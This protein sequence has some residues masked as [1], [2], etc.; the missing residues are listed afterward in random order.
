MSSH[1]RPLSARHQ[2]PR[3][4]I[5][6]QS[7]SDSDKKGA[8]EADGGD[9]EIE[10][11]PRQHAMQDSKEAEQAP[12]SPVNSIGAAS[13]SGHVRFDRDQSQ[14]R[15]HSNLGHSSQFHREA[16]RTGSVIFR[17]PR[18]I[19][20][21]H[22]AGS[23]AYSIGTGSR[24]L[25]DFG[26]LNTSNTLRQLQHLHSLRMA[27][28]MRQ[29]SSHHSLRMTDTEMSTNMSAN[30]STNTNN[31]HISDSHK[32]KSLN[33]SNNSNES[34]INNDTNENTLENEANEMQDSKNIGNENE[35]KMK[36]ETRDR[37]N[38]ESHGSK[39][40][41]ATG[42][43]T[44]ETTKNVSA[45][46]EDDQ[47]ERKQ[48]SS[49][50]NGAI[51]GDSVESNKNNNT[52]NDLISPVQT[53]PNQSQFRVKSDSPSNNTPVPNGTDIDANMT[54]MKD[55]N[56]ENDDKEAAAEAAINNIKQIKNTRNTAKKNKENI[57]TSLRSDASTVKSNRNSGGLLGNS[58]LHSRIS[59]FIKHVLP[60]IN[61]DYNNTGG[62]YA[63]ASGA[64]SGGIAPASGAASG[65]SVASLESQ[66]YRLMNSFSLRFKDARREHEFSNY[67]NE[68]YGTS[69]KIAMIAMILGYIFLTLTNEEFVKNSGKLVLTCLGLLVMLSA[70]SISTAKSHS[71][72]NTNNSTEVSKGN[73]EK[74][75]SKSNTNAN[76]GTH[77]RQKNTGMMNNM[78]AS[79]FSCI[80]GGCLLLLL[81]FQN[82][83]SV[84]MSDDTFLVY[85]I[86]C[87]AILTAYSDMKFLHFVGLTWFCWFLWNALAIMFSFDSVNNPRQ[88][89]SF[90]FSSV[91]VALIIAQIVFS[92]ELKQK[93]RHRR[94]QFLRRQDNINRMKLEQEIR[95]QTTTQQLHLPHAYTMSRSNALY[96]KSYALPNEGGLHGLHGYSMSYHGAYLTDT[97][98][99]YMQ[100]N[101]IHEFVPTPVNLNANINSNTPNIGLMP[102]S[103]AL[104]PEK[105]SNN[106][107]NSNAA[108]VNT[109]G[110]DDEARRELIQITRSSRAFTLRD[111]LIAALAMGNS[112]LLSD[113]NLNISINDEKVRAM[114]MRNDDNIN[115]NISGNNS[116]RGE[117][118]LSGGAIAA[119]TTMGNK[120]VSNESNQTA[121]LEGNYSSQQLISKSQ[122]NV[123]RRSNRLHPKSKA[124]SKS[125]QPNRD[126]RRFLQQQRNH[127]RNLLFAEINR[128]FTERSGSGF[129]LSAS[130][131]SGNTSSGEGGNINIIKAGGSG[132]GANVTVGTVSGPDAHSAAGANENQGLFGIFRGIGKFGL[133]QDHLDDREN[134]NRRRRLSLTDMN[135][136]LNLRVNT[137]APSGNRLGP[138]GFGQMP[139]D[140]GNYKSRVSNS[141]DSRVIPT[142]FIGFKPVPTHPQQPQASQQNQQQTRQLHNN[143]ATASSFTFNSNY[144]QKGNG[145]RPIHK[146][147][148]MTTPKQQQQQQLPSRSQTTEALTSEQEQQLHLRKQPQAL[149]QQQEDAKHT[150]PQTTEQLRQVAGTAQATSVTA[151]S[152]KGKGTG[153]GGQTNTFSSRD[154]SV[155][156]SHNSRTLSKPDTPASRSHAS[157]TNTRDQEVVDKMN[158]TVTDL[159]TIHSLQ[160][161]DMDNLVSAVMDNL[162]EMKKEEEEGDDN[163]SE[164]QKRRAGDEEAGAAIAAQLV[165]VDG[166]IYSSDYENEMDDKENDGIITA[167]NT[168]EF[169]NNIESNYRKKDEEIEAGLKLHIDNQQETVQLHQQGPDLYGTMAV[170]RKQPSEEDASVSEPDAEARIC[171]LDELPLWYQHEAWV[172]GGYR[173]NY[174]VWDAC[175]SMMQW[176]NETVNIWTEFGPCVIKIIIYIWLDINQDLIDA[177]MATWK[178][179]VVILSI[180][181]CIL[182]P[183]G[184]GFAHTFSCVSQ[185]QAKLWWNVDFA[186]IVA[187]CAFGSILWMQCLFYCEQNLQFL[188]YFACATLGLSTTVTALTTDNES[189]REV[190]LG[191]FFVFCLFLGYFIQLYLII[192]VP[193][194][195][196][197]P[198]EFVL[199]WGLAIANCVVA[200]AFRYSCFP[201][202]FFVK[203]KMKALIRKNMQKKGQSIKD[204]FKSVKGSMV[205]MRDAD[206]QNLME[207]TKSLHDTLRG[208]DFGDLSMQNSA[209]EKEM[210][211]K[212]EAEI[213]KVENNIVNEIERE[214]VKE[215]EMNRAYL[216]MIDRKYWFY[217]VFKS[218]QWWHVFINLSVVSSLFAW[219]YYFHWRIDHTCATHSS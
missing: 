151:I 55:Q 3:V 111:E 29:M 14:N 114:S 13:V 67:L 86:L 24:N 157:H 72:D 121:G 104:N 81:I 193:G 118:A 100:S 64:G 9:A 107:I 164:A 191:V 148:E 27:L 47:N 23:A 82:T 84:D 96:G 62:G 141:F 93:E 219:K 25:T 26:R 202:K 78:S 152:L 56:D 189:L 169:M 59:E 61:I 160:E 199:F 63:T 51:G 153:I 113:M 99:N 206:A 46:D 184:S 71:S 196:G 32:Q 101:T 136:V 15:S 186:T 167:Q 176:H 190:S 208:K 87:L 36:L 8:D 194:Y 205:S 94:I 139:I 137:A 128:D 218:H 105:V 48:D 45:R 120:G 22:T 106:T 132:T 19:S 122:S 18:P 144:L 127:N 213:E 185:K 133:H 140:L 215:D 88:D 179:I 177:G 119:P 187:A 165:P 57:T 181:G 192:S 159:A 103:A 98:T 91:N 50:A 158:T 217:Y 83:L 134:E 142:P 115:I 145:T 21:S 75:K 112:D 4:M 146:G 44:E 180:W 216:A 161:D 163:G 17:Q 188:Y 125:K 108:T 95:Q 73:N 168:A 154:L 109:D 126:Q 209:K 129:E 198:F 207:L 28:E 171:T 20:A 16:S 212:L 89:Q 49:A 195:N 183:V 33:I 135:N 85:Y 204:L 143:P 60:T 40:R 69:I 74:S 149:Q 155:D 12:F 147:L 2:S 172:L 77:A 70:F 201:E 30:M 10:S 39:K 79:V 156:D 130:E 34:S 35:N 210:I 110:L 92:G 211:T 116:N 203:S 175:I 1:S 76:T 174:S 53:M 124:K 150:Y 11:S 5:E 131:L 7:H 54:P 178:R 6:N 58:K 173:L 42:A 38:N 90:D 166:M 80:C 138:P 37:D 52:K 170:V 31:L 182:R 117:R 43:E 123:D 200:S 41:I 102:S 65:S 197:S 68:R 66:W 214:L 162:D 97:P